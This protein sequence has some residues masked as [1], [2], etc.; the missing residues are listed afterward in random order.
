MQIITTL[1]ALDGVPDRA[2]RSILHRYR[3]MIELATIYIIEP[4]DTVKSLEAAR[5]WP[6]ADFEFVRWHDGGIYECVFVV[7][8]YGEGQV[9]IVPQRP[10]I[11]PEL[12]TLCEQYAA[13]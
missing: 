10:G 3:E 2:V 13:Q 1:D 8:D 5:G 12:L 9:V 11:D 4:G 7:S 6:F